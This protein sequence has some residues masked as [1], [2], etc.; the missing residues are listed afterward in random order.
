[1][2][3]RIAAGEPSDP[4]GLAVENAEAV[5]IHEEADAFGDDAGDKDCPAVFIFANGWI[6]LEP[7]AQAFDDG[8]RD[9]FVADRNDLRFHN[10][11]FHDSPEKQKR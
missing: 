8:F 11:D 5:V 3:A 6:A 10:V 9:F 1:M 4:S 7:E 2:I